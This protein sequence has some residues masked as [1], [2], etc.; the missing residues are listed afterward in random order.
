MLGGGYFF[1]LSDTA[2]P[3]AVLGDGPNLVGVVGVEEPER[4]EVLIDN[5]G[6]RQAASGFVY[7]I[8][9]GPDAR[10]EPLEN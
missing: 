10:A 7:A 5:A 4:W 9:A 1:A 3:L 2:K 6:A 8:C